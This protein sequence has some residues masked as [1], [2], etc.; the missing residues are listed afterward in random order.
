MNT[1]GGDTVLLILNLGAS[2]RSVVNITSLLLSLSER[3]PAP[4]EWEAGL[5]LQPVRMF[6][7]G[8]KSFA[9]ARIWTLY[10][11]SAHSLVTIPINYEFCTLYT[12]C[13]QA[14]VAGGKSLMKIHFRTN[15]EIRTYYMYFTDYCCSTMLTYKACHH[16]NWYRRICVCAVNKWR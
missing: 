11:H 2:C 8:E 12:V 7:S 9:P 1:V 10:H 4:I 15:K 14:T 5:D 16:L 6:W 13:F 3:T